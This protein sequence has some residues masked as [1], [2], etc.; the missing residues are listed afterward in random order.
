MLTGLSTAAVSASSALAGVLLSRK[1]GHGAETDGFFAAY[2]VYIVMVLV[3]SALRVVVLPQ[4]ARSRSAGRLGGELAAWVLALTVPVVPVLAVALA[5]P[6]WLAA[7]LTGSSSGTRSHAAASLL[8]WLA[9]AASA[10]VFA[11]VCASALAALDDYVTAA[12]SYAAGAVV[13]VAVIVALIGHGV[14]AFGWGLAANG[15]IS[16]G[17]PL[18][19]LIRRGQLAP[20]AGAVPQRLRALAEGVALPFALQGLYLIANRFALGL[21]SGRSTTFSYAYLIASLLVAVTA[22]SLALVS[23]VP[24]AREAF[25]PALA[26]RHVVAATWVSLALVLGA[27][28]VFAIAG[29]KLVRATLGPRYGG[30]TGSELGRLVAYLAPW[31]LVSVALSVAFPLLFVRGKV[32]LLP[33]LAVAALLTHVPVEWGARALFGLA[34]VAAG[35]AVTTAG[36]LL[37]LLALLGGVRAGVRGLLGAAAAVAS[38]ALVAFGVPRLVLGPLPAAALGLIVYVAL[39]ALWRPPGLRA[40]WL[41]LRQ[42]G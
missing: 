10:Q 34:G 25:T 33:L 6:G 12:F 17:I 27:A 13:G 23:S 30:T 38:A 9:V 7:L 40:S 2:G 3:A 20:P 28:G 26:V 42:L 35:M 14:E 24:L 22:T 4:F 41:Y 15:A 37:V 29:E 8:P 1:F 5:E 16:L 19:T 31:M 21:G 11:G 39:L 36:V 18:A 32:R